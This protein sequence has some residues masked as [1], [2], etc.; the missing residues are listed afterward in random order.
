MYLNYACWFGA[1][2]IELHSIIDFLISEH[3]PDGGFNCQSNFSGARH[4]SMHS[5]ISVLEGLFEFYRQGYRYRLDEV[6]AMAKEGREFLLMHRLYKSDHTGEIIRKDFLQL[7]FPP[8]WKYNI[9]RALDH[10]RNVGAPWDDRMSDAIEVLM[11][12]RRPDEKWPVQAAH[13]GQ[14][15]FVMEKPGGPSR[16]NTLVALRVLKAYSS[17]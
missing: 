16:W 10:F 11:Q 15:H 14:V 4:S 3:M 13:A 17:A 9:L 1:A 5:T 12:K 7:S 2:E 6:L 8:R